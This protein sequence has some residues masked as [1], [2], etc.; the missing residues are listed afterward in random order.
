[1]AEPIN[2]ASFDAPIPGE[3]MMHELGARPWQQ[4][5]KYPTTEEALGF[6]LP[7]FQNEEFVEGLL[8]TLELGVPVTSI[9]NTIQTGAV[10][11]GLHT[12]DVGIIILPVLVEMISY[13][14]EDAGIEFNTGAEGLKTDKPTQTKIDVIMKRLSDKD[15]STEETVEDMPSEEIESEETPQQESGLMS[16]RM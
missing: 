5:P 15:N 14:A 1:M 16:R 12:I 11:E 4:P 2:N 6:Y 9:A 13:L 7:R 3:S 8:D 10:M